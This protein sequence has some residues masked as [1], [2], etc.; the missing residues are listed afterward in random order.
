[1]AIARIDP[2]VFVNTIT[3]HNEMID[4]KTPTGSQF[5]NVWVCDRDLLKYP[6]GKKL[7]GTNAYMFDG[8]GWYAGPLDELRAE[9]MEHG[10]KG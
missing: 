9:F 6:D 7:P 2:K 8:R 10:P 1:M 5:A 4:R 3:L